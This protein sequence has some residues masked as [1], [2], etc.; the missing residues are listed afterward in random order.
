[1][2][3]PMSVHPKGELVQVGGGATVPGLK[4][5]LVVFAGLDLAGG[6]G[7][8]LLVGRIAADSAFLVLAMRYPDILNLIYP[9]RIYQ[10]NFITDVLSN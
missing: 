1:M 8:D 5:G 10:H 2:I 6:L 4:W 7:G 3:G 9:C